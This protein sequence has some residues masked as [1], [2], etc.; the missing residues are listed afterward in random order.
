M[1]EIHEKYEKERANLVEVTKELRGKEKD[2]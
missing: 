2:Y 1:K